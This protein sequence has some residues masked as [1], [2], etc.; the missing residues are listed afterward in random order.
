MQDEY[1]RF[2]SK[3]LD[4]E[5]QL[6]LAPVNQRYVE[7]GWLRS[8]YLLAFAALGYSYFL[9]PQLERIRRQI[10]VPGDEI[11][12]RVWLDRNPMNY[13]GENDS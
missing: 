8:G 1:N 3:N 4:F 5:G 2:V 9:N 13:E 6:Q 11:V 10:A 12:P 7:V